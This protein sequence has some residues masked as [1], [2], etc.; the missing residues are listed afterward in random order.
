ML[1]AG[2]DPDFPGEALGAQD[3]H[4]VGPERSRSKTYRS[5]RVRTN[6]AGGAGTGESLVRV[7]LNLLHGPLYRQNATG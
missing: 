5:C 4:E 6:A 2:G 7:L 1:E 3:G